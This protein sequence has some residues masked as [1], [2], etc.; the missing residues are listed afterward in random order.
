MSTANA[1]DPDKAQLGIGLRL[2]NIRFP[3]SLIELFVEDAAGGGSHL[4]IGLE[5]MRRKGNFEL[6]VGLEYDGLAATDGVW[7]DK[8]DEIPTDDPDYVEFD[9]FG[10][11]AADVSFIWQQ[12]LIKQLA[13]R[14][15]AGIGLA[16]VLGDVLRT[17]YVCTTSETSSCGRDPNAVNDKTPE[18]AIPPVFP[19]LNLLFG[20][21]VRATDNIAINFEIGL[22]TLPYFGTTVGYYF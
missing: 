3:E 19:I 15:G 5:F 7:I 21:Q 22:H 8:G 9:G 14:Y 16:A 4:G 2:R 11:V 20:V 17:D 1:E 6:A 13:L 10:W 18:D 12:Q